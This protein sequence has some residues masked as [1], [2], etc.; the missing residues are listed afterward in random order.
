M[1]NF[2]IYL[3][4]KHINEMQASRNKISVKN[5]VRR[6][7]AEGFH[8]GVKGLNWTGWVRFNME[9]SDSVPSYTLTLTSLYRSKE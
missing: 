1:N 2:C 9:M 3:F 6:R 4:F 7:C 5:L 8:F